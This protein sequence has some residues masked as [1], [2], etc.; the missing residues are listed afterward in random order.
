MA[1]EP[2]FQ[3]PEELDFEIWA[4]AS[5]QLLKRSVLERARIIHDAELD[6]VWKEADQRWSEILLADIEGGRMERPD[7]YQAL[8]LEE[9]RLRDAA[10]APVGAEPGETSPAPPESVEPTTEL[11]SLRQTVDSLDVTDIAAALEATT[12]ALAWP[13]EKYAWLCAELSHAPARAEHVWA[14]HGLE[15]EQAQRA[16]REGWRD[17][18]EADADLR[19]EHQRLLEHYLEVLRG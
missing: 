15:E 19:A 9:L 3:R 14:L 7:R 16:V 1:S 12:A 2:P 17:R 5:A 18:L 8:C 10:A 6:K 13:V 11:A 4:Q